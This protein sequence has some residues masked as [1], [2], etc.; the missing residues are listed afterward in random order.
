MR[1]ASDRC[2]RSGITRHSW[3]MAVCTRDL[4]T[5]RRLLL[6]LSS[7][8]TYSFE[9]TFQVLQHAFNSPNLEKIGIELNATNDPFRPINECEVPRPGRAAALNIH[10]CHTPRQTQ[11]RR[12]RL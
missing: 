9:H 11:V 8:Q 3:R 1:F 5:K 7:L 10:G 6:L 2:E 4:E 12:G